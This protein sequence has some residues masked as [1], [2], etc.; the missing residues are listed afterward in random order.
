M[1]YILIFIWGL[2]A[3]VANLRAYPR[4]VAGD[5]RPAAIGA[6]AAHKRGP[7]QRLVALKAA[8]QLAR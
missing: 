4:N 7:T 3:Q 6:R 8:A 2:S 5:A 1:F